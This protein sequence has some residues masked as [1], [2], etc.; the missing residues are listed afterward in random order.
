MMEPANDRDRDDLSADLGDQP[1]SGD[2]Y[3]LTQTLMRPSTIEVDPDVLLQNATHL[4]LAEHDQLVEALSAHR[5]EEAFADGVQIGRAR[6]E[7]HN[8]DLSTLG[9]GGEASSEFVI[10]V[11]D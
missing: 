8:L 6:R 3:S 11:S 4:L 2:R 7:L 5:T 9:H 10:V 1:R